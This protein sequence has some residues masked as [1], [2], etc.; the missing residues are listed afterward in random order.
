MVRRLAA[1]RISRRVVRLLSPDSIFQSAKVFRQP[2]THLSPETKLLNIEAPE[3][4]GLRFVLPREKAASWALAR[5]AASIA[6]AAEY[7]WE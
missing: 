3:L 4:P 5:F 1:E 2:Q 6:C 7:V